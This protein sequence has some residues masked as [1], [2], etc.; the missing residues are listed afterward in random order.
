[1]DAS[2][3]ATDEGTLRSAEDRVSRRSGAGSSEAAS[4]CS[5]VDDGL[6]ADGPVVDHV[7]VDLST[8]RL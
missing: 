7:P 6:L 5:E 2:Q 4:M 8:Q 3:K 1:M